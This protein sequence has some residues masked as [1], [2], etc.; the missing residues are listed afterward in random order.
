[1]P[2]PTNASQLTTMPVKSAARAVKPRALLS[3]TERAARGRAQIASGQYLDDDG[4]NA[5]LDSLQ[6]PATKA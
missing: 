6:S 1:M 3:D 4:L 5:F 2:R